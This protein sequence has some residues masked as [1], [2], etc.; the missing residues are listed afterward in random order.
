MER[1]YAPAG[2]GAGAIALDRDEAHHLVRVRRVAAGDQV[3]AFDGRGNSWLCRL[4]DVGKNAAW[5]EVIEPL[6]PDSAAVSLPEVWL[7]TAVPK[8]DRFD[9][10]VEKAT[11]LGVARIVPLSCDRSVVEPRSTKLERLRRTVIEACKQCGRDRLAEITE[12]VRLHDFL[13]ERREG[14]MGLFAD[15]GGA[16]PGEIVAAEPRPDKI[17][18][19][20]GPEGG[21]TEGERTLAT[22]HGWRPVGLGPHVLRIETAAIA[23]SAVIWQALTRHLHLGVEAGFPSGPDQGF[24]R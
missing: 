7:G 20:V 9:W 24:S 12:P 23:A 10:I 22:S 19:C 13:S 3:V 17:F 6:V 4:G 21:W 1:V 11:E 16:A 14:D 8:G 15:R 18:V 2:V 5:L